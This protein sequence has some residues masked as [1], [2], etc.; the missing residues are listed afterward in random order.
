MVR[1]GQGDELTLY[2]LLSRVHTSDYIVLNV[3]SAR[4]NDLGGLKITAE[5]VG[6]LERFVQ[7]QKLKND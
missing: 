6:T 3:L 2:F 7:K 4:N 5:W 1:L